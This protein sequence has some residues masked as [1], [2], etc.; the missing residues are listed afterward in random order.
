[1]F[2]GI[3]ER[4]GKVKRIG[5]RGKTSIVSLTKPASWKLK[6]G[7]S[8]S[9]N[10]VCSTVVSTRTTS[11][12]VEYMPETL[13]VTT[14]AT[15]S[16]G[17]GVNLERSLKYGDRMDGHLVMGHVEGRGVVGKVEKEGRSRLLTVKLPAQLA[18]Y[19]VPRGSIAID[20]VSLTIARRHG[21][22]ITAALVPHTLSRT[23]L[24]ALSAGDSVN[25]ETDIRHRPLTRPRARVKRY[26]AKPLREGR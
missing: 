20:G 25:I 18:R 4:T 9:V 1:M 26:A 8:V 14:M 11:F 16:E 17:D 7:Q 2:T 13:R 23:T 6:L 19:A 12:S 3:I 10:G 5:T 22:W 15:L 21:P 24:G